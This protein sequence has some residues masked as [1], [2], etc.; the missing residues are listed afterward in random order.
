MSEQ[1]FDDEAKTLELSH[2]L[3]ELAVSKA[4]LNGGDPA[5]ALFGAALRGL[6]DNYGKDGWLP[7]AKRW[8]QSLTDAEDAPTSYN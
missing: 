7:L 2:M 6:Q 4:I 1:K 3:K 8:L 5:S